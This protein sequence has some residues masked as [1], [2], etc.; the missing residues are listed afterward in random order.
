M[1]KELPIV[2]TLVTAVF[3]VLAV[4]SGNANFMEGLDQ[5]FV[6]TTAAA[7]LLGAINQTRHHLRVICRRENNWQ[8]SIVLLVVLYV[9]LIAGIL[10]KPG[11]PYYSFMFSVTMVP[12]GA[13]VFAL[14]GFYISSAAYR[15][16]R[17][18]NIDAAVLLITAVIV[19]LGRAPIGAVI[20]RFFPAASAWIMNVPNT[21]VMRAI[22]LGSFI[23]AFVQAIKVM[24]GIERSH[25]GSST[26]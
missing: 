17:A 3:V 22:G 6:V 24:L 21:A 14:L 25:L 26:R 19:M 7:V 18:R 23:G 16:F 10:E 15:A 13:T 12:T 8:Y 1:R 4:Y 20:S 2:I 11:G 9:M 5:W